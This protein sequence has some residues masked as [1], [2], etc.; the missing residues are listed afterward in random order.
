M[1]QDK[2][3]L[4][5]EGKPLL[6][7]LA[8]TLRPMV[9]AMKVVGPVARYERFGYAVL[10]DLRSECGPLAGIEAALEAS[11]TDWNLIV[12]CDMPKLEASWLEYLLETAVNSVGV[13]CVASGTSMAEPNPLAAVWHRRTLPLVKK[14]L[15]EGKFRV[16][17]LLESIE[18]KILIPNDPG[19]LANWN[20]PEDVAIAQGEGKVNRGG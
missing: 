5:I 6:V 14:R 10:P 18:S 19:I 1:G 7:L 20:R 12:A 2:A 13:D 9:V 8:E 15:D 17:S 11:G 4:P 16:R 3:L